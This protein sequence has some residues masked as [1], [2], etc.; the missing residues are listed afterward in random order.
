MT[1]TTRESR[2]YAKLLPHSGVPEPHARIPLSSHEQ[3]YPA[4][5]GLPPELAFLAAEGFSPELLLDA[6]NAPSRG[7]L[8]V[9][10]LLVKVR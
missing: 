7:A 1:Q 5:R 3:T 8:P 10:Q 2:S 6:V 9:D 4:A